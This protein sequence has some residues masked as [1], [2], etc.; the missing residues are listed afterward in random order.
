MKTVIMHKFFNPDRLFGGWGWSI[1]EVWDNWNHIYSDP[2]EVEI[3]DDFI[4]GKTIADEKMY[5]K[6]G[7]DRGYE[8]TIER[9]DC[10]NSSPYLVG[11]S[12][13][14][15]IKL[16]VIGKVTEDGE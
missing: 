9:T 13:A 1:D 5:F 16:H 7:C 2:Y 14:E 8:L 4:L 3:P 15:S 12:P 10:E 11:G 6:A